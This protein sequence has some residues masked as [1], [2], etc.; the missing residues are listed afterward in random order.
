MKG[1]HIGYPQSRSDPSRTAGRAD[2]AV[3]G[4]TGRVLAPALALTALIAA[5]LPG[6]PASAAT[7]DV[8]PNYVTAAAGTTVASSITS[9]VG[10]AQLGVT[11]NLSEPN[12]PLQARAT[13]FGQWERFTFIS[14]GSGRWAIRSDAN[15]KY[16]TANLSVASTDAPLQA[17]AT[18]VGT[19]EI[20]YLYDNGDATKSIVSAGAQ[21]F[22][23][24]NYSVTNNPLKARAI[25]VGSWEK[26]FIPG[27]PAS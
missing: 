16:V 15:N 27:V 4:R 2:L 19:W 7:P 10:L 1:L 8:P 21:L 26:F 23:S 6:Q 22:V 18:T 13:D 11:A 24:A 20:F 14:Q 12:A 25:T 5:L 9:A 3:Q 17:R